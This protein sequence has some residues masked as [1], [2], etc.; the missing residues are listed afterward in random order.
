MDFK[1]YDFTTEKNKNQVDENLVFVSLVENQE[2]L[3]NL[4]WFKKNIDQDY[5]FDIKKYH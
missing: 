1:T 4:N 3:N 5:S 2:F